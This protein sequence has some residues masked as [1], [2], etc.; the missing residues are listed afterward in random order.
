MQTQTLALAFLAATTVGGIAWVF[1]YPYLSGEKKPNHAAHRW[2][3]ANRRRHEA[4][5]ARSAPAA[6][7]SR[8]R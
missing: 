4:A 1:L 5:S 3:A 2:R 8:D 7:R 6:N